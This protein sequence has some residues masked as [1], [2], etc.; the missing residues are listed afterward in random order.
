MWL[1]GCWPLGGWI[2][3][4]TMLAAVL[5]IWLLS[6]LITASQC[7]HPFKSWRPSTFSLAAGLCCADPAAYWSYDATQVLVNPTI[8]H[9]PKTLRGNLWTI[10][11][12]PGSRARLHRADIQTSH[13]NEIGHVSLR[14]TSWHADPSQLSWKCISDTRGG[15]TTAQ[16]V[17]F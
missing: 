12:L 8:V 16:G 3:E 9:Y 11:S 7:S 10:L 2:P 15:Q 1:V 17:I 4:R 5:F 14:G 6:I 13:W